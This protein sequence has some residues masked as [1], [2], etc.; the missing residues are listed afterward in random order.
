MTD[1]KQTQNAASEGTGESHC[2]TTECTDG[3]PGI[4]C[5]ICGDPVETRFGGCFRCADAESVI[6]TGEDMW[7]K[8]VANTPMEK[9]KY[10]LKAYGITSNSLLDRFD[11]PNTGDKEKR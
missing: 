8:K 1:D 2:S 5:Q 4:G 3:C 6:A 7:D 9:L 10:V 11:P